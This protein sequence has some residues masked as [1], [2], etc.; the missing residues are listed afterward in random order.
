MTFKVNYFCNGKKEELNLYQN[1]DSNL[2][3]DSEDNICNEPINEKISE[4]YS[5]SDEYIQCKCN[6][7]YKDQR[8]SITCEY[9]DDENKFI[10]DFELLSPCAT[11]LIAL[12]ITAIPPFSFLASL[13]AVSF[14]NF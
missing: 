4:L 10:I 11:A 2:N 3:T 5:D 9:E 1:S 13:I 12:N 8:V 7:C 6:K 14:L